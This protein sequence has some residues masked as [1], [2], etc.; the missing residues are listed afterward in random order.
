MKCFIL[1]HAMVYRANT[2]ISRWVIQNVIH[3]VQSVVDSVR[4][5]GLLSYFYAFLSVVLSTN[6][7]FILLLYQWFCVGVWLFS[8][9]SD[10]L[11]NP[12]RLDRHWVL[13]RYSLSGKT[14]YR[15]IS[16]SLEAARFNVI[17]FVSLWNLTGISA[18]LLSVCLSISRAIRK[19]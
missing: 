12:H 15:Q 10:G 1:R 16:R 8:C 19:V 5:K 9:F 4:A 6:N 3:S 18:A 7:V 2:W 13:N 17:I 14:S 11:I